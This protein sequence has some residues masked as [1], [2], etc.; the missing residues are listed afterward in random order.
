M[1]AGLKL[2]GIAW[3]VSGL[4]SEEVEK[5]SEAQTSGSP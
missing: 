2:F 1:D 3:R 5:K 4:A